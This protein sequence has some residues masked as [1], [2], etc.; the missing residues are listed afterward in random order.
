MVPRVVKCSSAFYTPP[1]TV[2]KCWC[3]GRT[4]SSCGLDGEG[5]GHRLEYVCADL[6]CLPEKAAAI[7][8]GSVR[9]C[10]EKCL[11]TSCEAVKLILGRITLKFDNLKGNLTTEVLHVL[12]SAPRI[13]M[14]LPAGCIAGMTYRDWRQG[15]PF[16]LASAHTL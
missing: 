3:F 16:M 13:N 12:T 2:A 7:L 4:L 9:R 1:K 10:G 15:S 6:Q 8:T 14:I 11:T 5:L